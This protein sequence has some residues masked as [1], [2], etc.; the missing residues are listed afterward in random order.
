MTQADAVAKAVFFIDGDE[1]A[2]E[3]Q[4]WVISYENTLWL[5]ATWLQAH[6]STERI[7]DRI[8][9]LAS[10]PHTPLQDGMFRLGR[11]M[12]RQLL[13]VDCPPELLRQF[14]AQTYP[15]LAHIPGPSSI[16]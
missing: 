14:G 10:F 7:P 15:S 3:Y 1:S 8:V 11:L 4:S 13:S 16:Q 12:P 2:S 9:P 5:V 6:A